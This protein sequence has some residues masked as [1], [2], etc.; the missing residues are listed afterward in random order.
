MGRRT[1]LPLPLP[2]IA[3]QSTRA[4]PL[5]G[6]A[7][8]SAG[9]AAAAITVLGAS[10][11]DDRTE[12]RGDLKMLRLSVSACGGAAMNKIR[13][14]GAPCRPSLAIK[15]SKSSVIALE[16]R[17]GHAGTILC[18]SPRTTPPFADNISRS[19]SNA[20]L[21]SKSR[22]IH[23]P[24]RSSIRPRVVVIGIAISCR[25]SATLPTTWTGPGFAS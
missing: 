14:P 3:T 17:R 12:C 4:A 25:H 7:K 15:P 11:A 9:I 22:A 2:A 13:A 23:A 19:N 8:G 6:L 10:T 18:K 1:A 21:S 24:S 5:Y 20:A 16:V